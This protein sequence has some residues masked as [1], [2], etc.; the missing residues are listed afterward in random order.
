MRLGALAF[1][2]AAEAALVTYPWPGNIPELRNVVERAVILQR[3]PTID[4]CDLPEFIAWSAERIPR[5]GGD[6]TVDE[7]EDEHIRR[8]VSRAESELAA[9]KIL[10]ISRSTLWRKRVA[11]TNT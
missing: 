5:I 7:I 3:A 2:A 4:T 1:T 10:G 9:A 6:F 11:G 8:V